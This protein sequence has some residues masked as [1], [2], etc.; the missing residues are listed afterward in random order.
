MTWPPPLW[1]KYALTLCVFVPLAVAAL[2]FVRDQ[3]TAPPP[4]PPAGP[5]ELTG[6]AA[7]QRDQAA[8]RASA[9]RWLMPAVALEHAIAA[10]VRSRIAH[11]DISGPAGKVSCDPLA[12]APGDQLTFGCQ[13]RAG[14]FSYPFRGVV[15]LRTHT[16]AWCKNDNIPIA[17]TLRVPLTPACTH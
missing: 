15:D 9:P 14:G 4:K 16:L 2:I 11:H 17:G 3:T 13:A 5:S 8:H 10:D 6:R 12:R 7:M 1:L